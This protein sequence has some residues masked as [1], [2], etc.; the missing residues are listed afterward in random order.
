MKNTLAMLLALV[1]ALGA[2]PVFAEEAAPTSATAWLLYFADPGWWPQHKTVD[3][4]ESETG[5]VATNAEV[6]GPGK[7][8]VGL[9]FKWQTAESALQFNLILQ[10]GETVFPGYYVDITEIRVNGTPIELKADN[11]YGT[12]HDDPASGFAPIYNNYWN[13]EATP[14]STGPDPATMR[15]FDGVMD[16]EHWE[17]IDPKQI[18]AGTKI[19]VDF[20]VA[21]EVGAEVQELGDKPA[22]GTQLDCPPPKSEEGPSAH[23]YYQSGGWWPTATPEQ[24]GDFTVTKIT[25]EGHYTV[26]A[27]FVDQGGWT[28]SGNGAEKLMLVVENPNGTVMDGMYL[29]VSAIRVNGEAIDFDDV[30]YGPTGYDN[31]GVF[32]KDDGYAI[33][34]DKWM[35][36][37]Q[38]GTVPWGH[39]TWNG[40]EG[41]TAAV[42]PDNLANVKEIEVDFFVT[43]TQNVVPSAGDD[44]DV[45][46]NSNTVGVAGLSLKDLGIANDWHN[47]VP[48]DVSKTGYQV[49]TLV[50]ADAHIIG[51]AFVVNNNGSLT[52][53]FDY[54]YGEVIEHSQCVKWFT[55]LDQITAE[56][57]AD[58]SNGKTGSDVVSVA[59]DL[60]GADIAFLSINN[61]VTWRDPIDAKG[62]SLSRYWRNTASWVAYRDG[63]KAMFETPAE[64]PAE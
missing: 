39:E 15:A 2:L 63:L 11:M 41:T 38:P 58:V 61:K 24:Q 1:L 21:A 44:P 32:T 19:E 5:V 3:Q 42:N 29:G 4:P 12:F 30:A 9:E 28:P 16:T 35:V 51:H 6:T 37:N 45:W 55:S 20:V 49:Y 56:A 18:V 17:I 10:N 36:E 14:G 23:L 27:Y 54:V 7:Y 47:I 8:T 13:A 59:N 34:Y 40:E 22:V 48:V 57:L 31:D 52:V 46:Y 62:N 50:G 64:V 25:G 60:G 53:E 26:K 33:L 43:A